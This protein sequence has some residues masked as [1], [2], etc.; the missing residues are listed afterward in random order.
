M[1]AI[2]GVSHVALTV[3]DME[4]S[5]EWYQRV[6][7]W[8]ELGRLAKGEAFSPRI[9]LFDPST[10]LVVGLSQPED[11]SGDDF[12]YRRV[13]LDHLAFAVANDEELRGWMTHL[14]DVGVE[15]S[16]IRE[17][18]LGKFVSLEDPDGIQLELWLTR[19]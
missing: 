17:L 8:T 10:G 11:G 15:H 2:L 7:G 18:D 9:L 12:D 16:P 19:R 13:G 3:R 14:D 4:T 5:A 6:F 1:P